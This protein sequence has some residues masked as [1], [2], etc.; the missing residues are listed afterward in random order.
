ME[1]EKESSSKVSSELRD[2][3]SVL[4]QK[5]REKDSRIYELELEKESGQKAVNELGQRAIDELKD[6]MR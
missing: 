5:L 3:I 2:R 4:E 6:R 1:L